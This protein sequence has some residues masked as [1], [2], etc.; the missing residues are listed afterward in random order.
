MESSL[1][2]YNLKIGKIDI[3]NHG[4]IYLKKKQKHPVVL[5]ALSL[6]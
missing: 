1:M 4:D 2:T 3:E 5:L 6:I